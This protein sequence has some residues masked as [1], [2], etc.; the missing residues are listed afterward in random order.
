MAAA[1]DRSPSSPSAVYSENAITRRIPGAAGEVE[2]R[3]FVP[4]KADGAYLN[5][6]GGGWVAGSAKRL[7]PL[8]ERL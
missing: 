4:P 1:D 5:I 3:C 8:D 6:H 2:L 7:P